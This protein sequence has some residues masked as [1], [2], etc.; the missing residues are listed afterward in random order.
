M[1]GSAI[2]LPASA[3]IAAGIG[4]G[5]AAILGAG[6]LGIGVGALIGLLL[7]IGA[8]GLPEDPVVPPERARQERSEVRQ[9]PPP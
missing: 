8:D 4:L 5:E 3:C 7:W 6:L 9:R 2:G 1:R